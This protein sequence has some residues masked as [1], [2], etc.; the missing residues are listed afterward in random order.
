MPY[1]Y[2]ENIQSNYEVF[3]SFLRH[4]HLMSAISL[5]I[6]VRLWTDDLT[7]LN[8]VSYVFK[9]QVNI[10]VHKVMTQTL[11]DGFVSP[12]PHMGL[13]GFNERFVSHQQYMCLQAPMGEWWISIILIIFVYIYVIRH[14][15][16]K[17]LVC[18]IPTIYAL[19]GLNGLRD[20]LVSSHICV[21]RPQWVKWR[22]GIIRAIYASPDLNGLFDGLV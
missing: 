5:P 9:W 19:S 6:R 8:F 1:L 15:W 20:R 13:D 4:K 22:V 11:C 21:T 12:W 10:G 16:V 7:C 17:W 14:Q 3:L 18:I 2:I